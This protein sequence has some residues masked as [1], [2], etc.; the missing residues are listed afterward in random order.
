MVV[1]GGVDVGGAKQCQVLDVGIVVKVPADGRGD[2][3]EP[4]GV[5]HRVEP[6]GST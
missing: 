1:A 5:D 4:T 2:G 6:V 3:V